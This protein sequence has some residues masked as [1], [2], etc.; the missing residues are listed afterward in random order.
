MRHAWLRCLPLLLL[1]PSPALQAQT[2]K[3]N[4]FT[5]LQSNSATLQLPGSLTLTATVA[6]SKETGGMPSGSVQFF[7][8]TTH[9]LGTAALKAIPATQ[10]FSAPPISGSFGNDPYGLFTLPSSISKYSILGVLDYNTPNPTTG[11]SYPQLTIYSGQGAN[12]FQTSTAYQ[13]TNSNIT[14]TYPGVDAF[15]V[16]DFN[17]DGIL[18]MNTIFCPA[19]QAPFSIQLLA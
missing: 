10:N 11:I 6:P 15:A 14:G 4:S 3:A 13:L 5:T 12:L 16:G 1:L 7:N 19:R 8:N 2:Q 9:S 18:E 17:H